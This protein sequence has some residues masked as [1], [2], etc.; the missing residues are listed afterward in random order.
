MEKEKSFDRKSSMAKSSRGS[1]RDQSKE[2]KS[3]SSSDGEKSSKRS[4]VSDEEKVA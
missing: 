2:R 1:S 3:V 4:S